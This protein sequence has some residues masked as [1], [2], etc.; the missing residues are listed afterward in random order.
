M[1]SFVAGYGMIIVAIIIMAIIIY[2]IYSTSQND[3]VYTTPG[4]IALP[5]ILCIILGSWGLY[6]MKSEYNKYA[7]AEVHEKPAHQQSHHRH[8]PH[9]HKQYDADADAD[10]DDEYDDDHEADD[11]AGDGPDKVN[12]IIKKSQNSQHYKSRGR[13]GL[14]R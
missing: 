5:L 10:F 12:K 3:V 8:L 11:V 2:C 1:A 9:H 13:R 4:A 7:P 14:R 6:I